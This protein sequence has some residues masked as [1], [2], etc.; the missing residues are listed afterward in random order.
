MNGRV[1]NIHH[2]FLPSFKGARPYQQAF[3]KGVKI[4]GASAHYVTQDIDEGQI[5]E[6]DI[7]R[8]NHSNS[9][10]NFISIGR[11]PIFHR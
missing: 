4:I 10:D 9:L 5:I 7:A 3:E 11:D 8:V 1:I 2:S 6:Q